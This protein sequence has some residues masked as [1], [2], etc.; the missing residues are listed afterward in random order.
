MNM[1]AVMTEANRVT[2]SLT[3][4]RVLPLARPQNTTGK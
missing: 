3:A 4:G 2:A 1:T